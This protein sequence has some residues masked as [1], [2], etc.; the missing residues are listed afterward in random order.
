VGD[1]YNRS[2]K[3][4]E[5]SLHTTY[6]FQKGSQ[7][8][9]GD[10]HTIHLKSL[11]PAMGSHRL[12]ILCLG[13]RVPKWFGVVYEPGFESKKAKMVP[14][15]GKVPRYDVNGLVAFLDLGRLSRRSKKKYTAFIFQK[16]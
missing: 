4:E 12:A 1:S 5:G 8:G 3:R 11:L 14:K 10:L 7:K 9:R 16:F 2:F 6:M 15:S 13:I